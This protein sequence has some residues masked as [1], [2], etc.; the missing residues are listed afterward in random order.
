MGGRGPPVRRRNS[1]NAPAD[2]TNFSERFQTLSFP[3]QIEIQVENLIDEHSR[4]FVGEAFD[5]QVKSGPVFTVI[6]QA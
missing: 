6:D 3:R 4:S 5:V 2:A 1:S